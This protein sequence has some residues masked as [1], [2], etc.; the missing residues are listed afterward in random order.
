MAV[1]SPYSSKFTDTYN[2]IEDLYKQGG[3]QTKEERTE[4]IKSKGLDP[5]EYRKTNLEYQNLL[6][7]DPDELRRPGFG[8][9]RAFGRFAGSLGEG[10][11]FISEAVAPEFTKKVS[12]KYKDIVPE[13]V[14]KDLQATFK[15]TDTG[16]GTIGEIAS[17]FVGGLGGVKA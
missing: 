15:P 13:S 4:Y 16:F 9:G 7:T 8:I 6:K 10:V 17:F 2:E 12:E 5:T 14:Q 3:L 1:L 11:G